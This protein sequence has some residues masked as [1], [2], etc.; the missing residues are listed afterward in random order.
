MN[1]MP[2]LVY[3]QLGLGEL[4]PTTMTFQLADRFVKIPRGIVEDMLIK[5]DSFYFPVDF[6]VLDTKPALNA[7]T[8]IHVILGRPFLATSNTLINYQS[9]VMK[10][11]FG[12]MTVELNIFDISKQVPDN[13]DICEVNMIGSL[14]HD[15]F[16]QTSC[17]DPLKACL[18][19]FDYNLDTEKSIEE[20]HALLDYVSLL[21]IDSWQPKVVPLPLPS[22]PFPSVVEPPKLDDF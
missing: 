8:Q 16:L 19:R 5:V 22:S 10:I 6:V 18:T 12:N 15:T 20:V 2:Y 3:L 14:V 13:E 11:S 9:G 21:S 17:K 1:L 7:N 4:K